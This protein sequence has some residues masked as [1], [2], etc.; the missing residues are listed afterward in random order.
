[1]G[2]MG[3][4]SRS[5]SRMDDD[6]RIATGL[7]VL[8]WVTFAWFYGGAGWNGHA[9]FDLTRAL[10]ER[11][12][13]YIDGYDV[14]TG[15]TSRGIDGHTYI[16]KPPGVSFLAAIPYAAVCAVERALR[17]PVEHIE[18]ANLW[19]VTAATCG[20]SGALIGAIL[21]LYGRRRARATA[22]SSV[23]VSLAILFGPIVFPYS[24]ILFAHVPP[25]LFLPLALTPP[26]APPPVA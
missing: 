23:G 18:H 4:C 24:T 16:N 9:Q 22:V 12:T 2:G 8:A 26:A 20:V 7:F 10:I 25:P 15:D 1:M 19:I 21:Y 17:L 11:Q 3:I 14:N 13:L 5:G 6:R